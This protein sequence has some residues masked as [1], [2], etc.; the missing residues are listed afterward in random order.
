MRL[1]GGLRF[2]SGRAENGGFENRHKSVRLVR[3]CRKRRRPAFAGRHHLNTNKPYII[4]RSGQDIREPDSDRRTRPLRFCA[5][6]A[7][8]PTSPQPAVTWRC[9]WQRHQIRNHN[10]AAI[11]AAQMARVDHYHVQH[12]TPLAANPYCQ[13]RACHKAMHC[14][15]TSPFAQAAESL[16]N[17]PA[18]AVTRRSEHGGPRDISAANLHK[19]E[20]GD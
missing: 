11:D 20:V 4:V 3:E 1:Y 9:N 2:R 6:D 8:P 12:F 19:E 18:C 13:R 5:T 16:P 14:T 7:C 17:P 10:I 15:N